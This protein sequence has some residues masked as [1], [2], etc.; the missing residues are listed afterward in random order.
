MPATGQ[1]S[2]GGR[3]KGNRLRKGRAGWSGSRRLGRRS[4]A[5]TD[6]YLSLQALAF[7]P[8]ATKEFQ[9]GIHGG[10]AKAEFRLAHSG[11]G[12]PEI[13]AGEDIPETH[14]GDAFGDLDALI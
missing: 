2:P 9:H 6:D 11:Q 8:L 5:F 12:N 4:G 3:N 10:G 14:D 13:L 7:G 1:D